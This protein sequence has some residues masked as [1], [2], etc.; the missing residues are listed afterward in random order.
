MCREQFG[1]G[2]PPPTAPLQ[3]PA[4][5]QEPQPSN[6]PALTFGAQ[7]QQHQRLR[8][9][10]HNAET[11]RNL[12]QFSELIGEPPIS[13]V[14]R[15]SEPPIPST[16]P[17]PS[18]GKSKQKEQ[19]VVNTGK[20]KQRQTAAQGE[21]V[22]KEQTTG[23]TSGS[24]S[25]QPSTPA[26]LNPTAPVFTPSRNPISKEAL[27][28]A[29]SRTPTPNE[30]PPS[31]LLMD[32]LAAVSQLGSYGFG[33]AVALSVEAAELADAA[34]AVDAPQLAQ[35]VDIMSDAARQAGRNIQYLTFRG[36]VPT[37]DAAA[38]GGVITVAPYVNRRLTADAISDTLNL[39]TLVDADAARLRR[40]HKATTRALPPTAVPTFLD[41]VTV[42]PLTANHTVAADTHAAV[43]AALA[44][45]MPSV[46]GR[47]RATAGK[48]PT[49][50]QSIFLLEAPP[51]TS[52]EAPERKSRKESDRSSPTMGPAAAG[53]A[54][55]QSP[56][57]EQ[58]TKDNPI[59]LD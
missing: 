37:V 43:T 8:Q 42:P 46:P 12:Q 22:K 31:K 2:M 58:T 27:A 47:K 52:P 57:V 15:P 14:T 55:V 56:K 49:T 53:R 19:G 11:A 1:F 26:Q 5:Q 29:P 17:I 59:E 23:L 54:P 36:V 34:R 41:S 44:A 6:G 39:R 25:D 20:G 24:T 35:R 30:E 18:D 7:Q 10:T 3:Q 16:T 9:Q 48:P 28:Y 13:S 32:T 40:Y 21:G 51:G 4:P 50:F 38:T 45:T 33:A